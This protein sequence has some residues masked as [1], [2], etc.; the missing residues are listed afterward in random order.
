MLSAITLLGLIQ[1]AASIALERGDTF[2]MF[3]GENS[4]EN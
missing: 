1:S 4:D 2:G 3:I